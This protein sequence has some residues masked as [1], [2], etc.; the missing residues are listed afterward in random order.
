M[1]SLSHLLDS[2]PFSFLNADIPDRP[3]IYVISDLTGRTFYIGQSGNLRRRLLVDHR[4]GNG[5]SS[6]FR[7]KLARLKRLD[8]EPAIT[9]YIM[10]SCTVRL[11]E[12][13]SEWGR[14]EMEHFATA[15]LSPV[16]NAP[17]G[18]YNRAISLR[19]AG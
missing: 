15:I 6:I 14:L 17:S 3:G 1:R 7:R 19:E 16:L 2:T 10:E 4:K 11:L 13:D 18:W 5:K 9:S 12:I 8:T